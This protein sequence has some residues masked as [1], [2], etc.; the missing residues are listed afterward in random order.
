MAVAARCI[1]EGFAVGVQLLVASLTFGFDRLVLA[2][3]MTLRACLLFMP[4]FEGKST[5]G[6]MVELKVRSLKP[7]LLMT[8]HTPHTVELLSVVVF[9]AGATIVVSRTPLLPLVA[10]ETIDPAM[11][12][13]KPESGGSMIE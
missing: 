7:S 6:V 12:S 5:H 2:P 8:A 11:F 4:T 1:A 3:R 10:V 9:V 13:P